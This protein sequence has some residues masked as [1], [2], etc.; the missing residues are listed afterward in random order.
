MKFYAGNNMER[1]GYDFYC[2]IAER[3]VEGRQR[4]GWTQ[5]QLAKESGIKQARISEIENVKTRVWLSDVKQLAKALDVTEDWLIQAELDRQGRDCRYLVWNKRFD[6]FKFY[7]TATSARMAFLMIHESISKDFIWFNPRDRAIVKL[8][9]VPVEKAELAA[10]FPKRKPG[11]D[12]AIEPDKAE[13]E[14]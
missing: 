6:D 12:D 8:V 9:G 3:V 5:E 7:Q 10:K 14:V 13:S 11:Q 1:I 4:K 2:D